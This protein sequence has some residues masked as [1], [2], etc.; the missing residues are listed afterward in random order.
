MA[1]AA[2]DAIEARIGASWTSN[3][4]T[5]LPVIGLST[6]TPS[7]S[8]GTPFLEFDYPVNNERPFTFG[9]PGNN[10]YRQECVFRIIVNETIG[11]G[12]DRLFGWAD[13]LAA[14]YRG[15][16]F[17]SVQCF[18]ASIGPVDDRGLNANYVQIAIAVRYWFYV[19]G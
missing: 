17:S 2:F 7:P 4:G 9:D 14:L 15:K 11:I 12:L 16:A 19:T 8:D 1:K 5:V 10:F 6:S 13:E 3:D 18:E